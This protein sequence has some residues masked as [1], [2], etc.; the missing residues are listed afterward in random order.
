MRAL[1]TISVVVSSAYLGLLL[2]HHA[3]GPLSIV[4]KVASTG[5]L[6]VVAALVHHRHKLLILA[7]VFSVNGDLLLELR[8]VGRL[9][10]EQVFLLGLVAF[11]IA[12]IFYIALFV[13]SRSGVSVV[14][15]RT[16]TVACMATLGTAIITVVVLWPGLA[17]M[18][19]PVLAYSLVLVTMVISA[20]YALFTPKVAIG[21]LLFFASD[22]MLAINI[23]GYPF[24]G[25]RTL[26]WITYYTA[27]LLITLGVISSQRS[28]SATA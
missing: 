20:Q 6:V 23:F 22:T 18:R 19:I 14:I 17:E 27:Q 4:L 28:V 10:P 12:H 9:G 8:R 24:S 15:G 16:R 2:T 3:A 26:V 7:L 13:R 25:A 21:A 1:L 5:L 11:L